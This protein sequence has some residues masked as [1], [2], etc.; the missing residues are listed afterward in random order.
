MAVHLLSA[1][2]ASLDTYAGRNNLLTSLDARIKI[3]FVLAALVINLLSK[4]PWSPLI[5]VIL[6]L[7]ALLCIRIPARLL[8]L[9][10]SVPMFMAC[11][12]L[13]AQTF[14]SGA[15][16]IFS[17]DYGFLRLAAYREGLIAGLIIMCRVIAG[18]SLILFLSMSTPAHKLLSAARWC[19]LPPVLIELA[20]LIYRYVFVL[21]EEMS[22]MYEIQKV[23]LGYCN[24]R[25]SMSSLSTLGANVILRA[26][27]RAEYVY[28]AMTVRGYSPDNKVTVYFRLDTRDIAGI[29]IFAVLLS[30]LFIV[31]CVAI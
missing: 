23:R 18:T 28:E 16:P 21:I 19:K 8:I 27:D 31:G 30:L 4:N 25:R 6:C 26:Y 10:L 14:M 29:G 7:T 12:V 9:R 24:W 20:L 11:V 5:I 2:A 3:A 13:I 1:D 17:L 15:T 22:A